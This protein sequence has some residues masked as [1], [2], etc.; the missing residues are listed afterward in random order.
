MNLVDS[1]ILRVAGVREILEAVTL[2]VRYLDERPPL[3]Q[4]RDFQFQH[5]KWNPMVEAAAVP[6]VFR[7]S[8]ARATTKANLNLILKRGYVPRLFYLVTN[9]RIKACSGVGVTGMFK[10][11]SAKRSADWK[12]LNSVCR[13][14]HGNRLAE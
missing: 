4:L 10:C 8:E 12:A 6:N 1:T 3:N 14:M 13:M 7:S 2:V 11:G 5:Q 9:S